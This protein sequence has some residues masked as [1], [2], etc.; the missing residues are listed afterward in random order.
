[1]PADPPRIVVVGSSNTDMVVRAERIPQPGETVVGGEFL[2]AAG[3]KGANQAVAAARLGGAVTF[4]V[5]LG[6]DPLGEEALRTLEAEGLDLRYAQRD[7]EAASGVALILVDA[8]G[9]NAI[10]VAPGA[11]A[12]LS[13]ADVER[14]APAIAACRCLLTQL[15]TPLEPVAKAIALA[16]QAGATVILNPAPYQPL[17]DDFLAQVDVLTP[18]EV[19]AGQLLG[20]DA[21]TAETAFDAARTLRRRGPQSVLLTAGAAGAFLVDDLGERHYPALSVTAVD[22]TAAGDAFSGAL[23][24]ALAAGRPLRLSAEFATVVAALTVPRRRAAFSSIEGR[25]SGVSGV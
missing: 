1:V 17:P 19:E 9:E 12:R 4:V 16:R 21:V 5:R 10:A 15:E 25:R 23:A 18:N 22:T 20:A 7:P 6:A 3:G 13:A 14:A 8:G 24:V 2:R 11:N